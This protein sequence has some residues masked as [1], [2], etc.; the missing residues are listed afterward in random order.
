MGSGYVRFTGKLCKLT[1]CMPSP[2][3]LLP[4]LY[5][6]LQSRLAASHF[7]R[8]LVLI[9]PKKGWQRPG[10]IPRYLPF[11]EPKRVILTVLCHRLVRCKVARMRVICLSKN[12][13]Q[14]RS[15]VPTERSLSLKYGH[16]DIPEMKRRYPIVS[17]DTYKA[18]PPVLSTMFI[19]PLVHD[20]LATLPS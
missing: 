18:A 5:H 12:R 9:S 14:C 8:V 20:K 4:R 10:C 3:A 16:L 2:R 11:R 15:F 7:L 1:V 17:H 6:W 13:Q 19:V